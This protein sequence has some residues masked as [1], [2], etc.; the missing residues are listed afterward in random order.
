MFR[1]VKPKPNELRIGPSC[2]LYIRV[3]EKA[4]SVAVTICVSKIDAKDFL[5]S[6][7]FFPNAH[8]VLPFV[9]WASG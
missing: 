2:S 7:I 1:D 8:L 5:S 9:W 4:L 6:S 3:F